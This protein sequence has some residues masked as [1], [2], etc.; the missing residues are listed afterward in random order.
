MK[1]SLA[2]LLAAALTLSVFLTGCSGSS[3]SSPADKGEVNVYNWG[4][5]IDESVLEQFTKETGIKVNYDT[6]ESNESMYGVIKNDGASYDVVIPS[7]YMIGR[8]V[9]EDMLEPLDFKNIPN[10]S[11]LDESLKN[12][13]YDPQNQ[14]SV[15][16]MTGLMGIIYNRKIV[17][18]TV[19]SWGIMFDKDYAGQILMFNNPRDAI[20]IALKYLGYSL[21]TTNE[22]EI[23]EA[24]DLLVSEKPL[25]QS[26]VMDDIFDKLQG[27]VAAIG[28]YYYGD[29]LTMKEV[30]PDLEFCL[31]KEGTNRFVDAMCILKNAENK[32]NAEKFI[33]FM[34]RTD[35]ALKNTETVCYS[36]PMRS[37][38]IVLKSE[39]LKDP[40]AYPK[41]DILDKCEIYTNLPQETLDLYNTEWL[42]LK[43]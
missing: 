22:A 12:P 6:F 38:K 1:K 14:Y 40:F 2:M 18:K 20:G 32:D 8:M 9:S 28:A 17:T 34:C 43:N 23:K 27:N 10:A 41:Q 39:L 11:D 19:D 31:P 3:S 5:Y 13:E 4:V 16:Y 36:T 33:N 26:Y 21:N 7:D 30:N 15:P 35:I 37:V 42:R 24:V 29:Y 25:V